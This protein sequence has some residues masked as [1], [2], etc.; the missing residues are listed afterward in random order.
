VR[1]T[2]FETVKFIKLALAGV[3]IAFLAHHAVGILVLLSPIIIMFIPM[4]IV[5]SP[6]I[7]IMIV[8][9]ILKALLD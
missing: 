2:H 5:L 3:L 1:I 8:L 6:V 4:L 7:L 9:G